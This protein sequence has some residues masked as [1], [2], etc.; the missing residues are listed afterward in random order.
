MFPERK[1]KEKLIFMN[2]PKQRYDWYNEDLNIEERLVL[3]YP[4]H[5][6]IPAEL[7]VIST[8]N[9]DQDAIEVIV[10]I[11]SL[12]AHEVEING[13][14]IPVNITGMPSA[15]NEIVVLDKDVNTVVGSQECSA[16]TIV[17]NNVDEDV[18]YNS[19]DDEDDENE[20]EI[21]HTI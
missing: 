2:R 18:D 16:E 9:D 8:G 21:Y 14:L 19:S 6:D 1:K 20:D 17:V 15:F 3:P 11:E 4:T 10:P 13:S 7:P 5:P 12:L